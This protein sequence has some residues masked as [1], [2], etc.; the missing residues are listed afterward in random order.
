MV[1]MIPVRL[2]HGFTLA[3]TANHDGHHI[4][5][6]DGNHPQRRYR[7]ERLLTG[8]CTV[9]QQ[10][11]HREADKHGTG[12]AHEDLMAE[13]ANAQISGQVRK[14]RHGNGDRQRQLHTKTGSP[15]EQKTQG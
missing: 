1:Q 10:P 2:H 5:Q 11:H 6:R 8:L 13:R 15:P 9:D 4:H 7:P 3:D 12:I 14:Q